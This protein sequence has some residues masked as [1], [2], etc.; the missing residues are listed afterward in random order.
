MLIIV[1]E[2]ASVARAIKEI[3]EKRGVKAVVLGLRGHVLDS[4]LEEKFRDWWKVDPAKILELR[5]FKT[6]IRDSKMYRE[7]VRYFSNN[8]V[9][10]LVIAT[11]NDPEGELIGWEVY[12][13]F[14]RYNGF[15]RITRMRFN[16]ITQEDIWKAWQEREEGLNMN[17]VWKSAFRRDFDL[18]TGAAFT[19]LL[20]L[21]TRKRGYRG[22]ISWGSCQIPTLNYIVERE[23]EIMNFKPKPYWIISV[24]LETPFGEVFEARS[25]KIMDYGK[26]R[27]IFEEV[28]N[29]K[30][31]YVVDY[32]ETVEVV[33]RPKPLRTDELLRDLNKILGISTSKI[34]RIAEELYSRGYI[35][36]PR[37]DT[38]QW[39][40]SFNF[41]ETALIALNGLKLSLK[42][43]IDR[44]KPLNGSKNDGAHP[45]IY[46]TKP[47][48]KDDSVEWSVWEYVARRFLAN[49]YGN[50]AEIIKQ[51][52]LIR[53]GRLD[54]KTS[55][56]IFKKTGFF[57]IFPYFK[58]E[59]KS[60]PILSS[61][62][63]LR[64]LDV[65]LLEE[66]T[67]PPDRLTESELLK[68]M[69]RDHIGTDA[70]RAD[71]PDIIV[72][73]GYAKRV[74]KKVKPTKLGI[75]LI[76]C[77]R[78]VSPRLVSPETRRMVE[79]Y[80]EK[81]SAGSLSYEKA[82]DTCL[83]IYHKLYSELAS[84][85]DVV[86]DSLIKSIEEGGD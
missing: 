78:E 30:E 58:P 7:L 62:Q 64:V 47:Y 25:E 65:R 69:E 44:P 63:V 72:E 81:I 74:K 80:M 79:E 13:I 54:L 57:E 59:L 1:A 75:F 5:E 46:P 9:E 76:K 22:L 31:A 60:I 50:D 82:L 10:E 45:P 40:T 68:L 17:W 48:I 12:T 3:I 4:D 32:R 26:A 38:N 14:R 42:I 11:D 49:V 36:Y 66:K 43:S 19:R 61:K 84:R 15:A 39:S 24:K 16:A 27:E 67:K 83:Q 86:A 52:A 55:G 77:L 29:V 20:T 85:I 2:K 18:A 37:T 41:H 28:K 73:R 51:R 70:T 53:I 56:S 33:R 71:Y 6:V 8:Y 23:E 34:L 35:S 21:S